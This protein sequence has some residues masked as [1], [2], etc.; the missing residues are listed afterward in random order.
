MSHLTSL[1]RRLPVGCPSAA[2]RLPVGDSQQHCPKLAQ[3]TM[4]HDKCGSHCT[5]HEERGG[6]G[7]GGRGMKV[8][9]IHSLQETSTRGIQKV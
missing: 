4:P 7:G 3:M 6:G 9:G 8:L 2:R 5:F 1:A